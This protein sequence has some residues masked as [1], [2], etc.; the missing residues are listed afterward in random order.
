MENPNG[1]N[2]TRRKRALG[3]ELGVRYLLEGSV[4][5][6]GKRLRISVQ[7]L[8]AIAGKPVWAQQY[9]RELIDI[10]A[11]QDE[12]TAS[13]AANIEP[14]LIA[15]EGVR[16]ER[17]STRDMHAWDLVARALFHFWKLTAVESETAVAI[18]RQAVQRHPKHAPAHSLL[19]FALLLSNFMGWTA[20]GSDKEFAATIAHRAVALDESDPWGHLALAFV[21]FTS[22]RTDEAVRHFRAP[23]DLNPNFPAAAGFMAFALAFDGQSKEATRWFEEALRM[24]PRRPLHRILFWRVIRRSL[25]GGSV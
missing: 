13:V 22:R 23:L 20:S 25:H 16:I 1:Q 8:D 2:L 5:K 10:F 21:A 7:L 11:L 12:I 6:R 19:A 24:S 18:L 3:R 14:R 4:R 9:D 17:R 15:A